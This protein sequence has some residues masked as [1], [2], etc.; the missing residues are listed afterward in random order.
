VKRNFTADRPNELWVADFTYC[1]THSGVVYIA[2][3]VDVFSRF[4]V[5]PK[6]SMSM[7]APLVVDAL[8]MAAWNRRHQ[9]LNGLVCH[10]DYAEVGVK[11]RNRV[12]TCLGEV[13]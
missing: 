9:S 5:G 7:T 2:F 4:I 3:I 8:N 11:L 13:G 10:N 12:L 1:S 6:V